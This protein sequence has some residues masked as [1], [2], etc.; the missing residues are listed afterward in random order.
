[1]ATT[2]TPYL[3]FGGRCDEA[4]AFYQ[5]ALGAELEMLMRFRESPDPLPEEMQQPGIED[6]VMHAAL[7]IAGNTLLLSDGCDM[8]PGFSS[9]SLAL[10]V[11]TVEQAQAYFDALQQE[12][13][14]LMPLEKTFWS[15]LYGMVQDRFQLT[16]MVMVMPAENAD[17]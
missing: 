4:I 11:D 5:S 1:M 12:G 17:P 8:N 3:F 9:F 16:W 10:S 6:K 15:P 2:L 7:S 14:V 13:V